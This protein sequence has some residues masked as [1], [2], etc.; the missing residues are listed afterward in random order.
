VTVAGCAELFGVAR[1][2][3]VWLVMADVKDELAEYDSEI[4]GEGGLYAQNFVKQ[5]W[6]RKTGFDCGTCGLS[7]C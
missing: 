6:L 3:L 2:S 5:E 7:F 4:G 1:L